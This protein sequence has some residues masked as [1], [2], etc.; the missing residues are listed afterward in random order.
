MPTMN[1]GKTHDSFSTDWDGAIVG[2]HAKVKYD[3]VKRNFQRLFQ[4]EAVG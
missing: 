2:Y 3:V 4:I 1:E